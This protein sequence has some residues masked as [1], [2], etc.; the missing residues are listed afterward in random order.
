[1][2]AGVAL[3]VAI[4]EEV[5]GEGAPVPFQGGIMECL[6]RAAE[7]GFEAVELHV[8]DPHTLDA[9]A[10]RQRAE[11]L[12]VR[13]AAI[14]TGLEYSRNGLCLTAP[15]ARDRMMARD[16]MLRHIEFAAEFR[17]VVFIGL[18]RGKAGEHRLVP[19]QLD[20]FAEELIPLA[21]AAASAGVPTGLEPVAYYFSDLLNTTGETVEFLQRPGL[22][23]VGLLIDT[24]HI[25]LEDPSQTEAF[26]AGGS[27]ITH[28]Q[29]SDSNRRYP[30]AGNIDWAEVARALERIDFSGAVALEVLPIPTGELAAARGLQELRRVFRAA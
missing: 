27:R 11:S 30:G 7:L 18:I 29:A 21:E 3:G 28:V 10:I 22:Q 5:L 15:D 20:L 12:G 19:G 26:L 23:S 13:V 16:A 14:G 2:S 9:S 6:D 25:V 1:M 24:H 8:R 4:S 17:A